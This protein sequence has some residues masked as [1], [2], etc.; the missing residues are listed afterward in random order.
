MNDDTTEKQKRVGRHPSSGRDRYATF[1]QRA[2]RVPTV[3]G[4][5]PSL[6][7]M[8]SE[9]HLAEIQNGRSTTDERTVT[10]TVE[11]RDLD[12]DERALTEFLVPAADSDAADRARLI[13]S[14]ARVQPDAK[15][16]SFGNGAATFLGR[17][18]L[19]IAAF[20]E[21]AKERRV[22]ARAARSNEQDSLFAA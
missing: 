22:R 3:S 2:A 8:G 7:P 21:S 11:T 5:P 9:A 4:R 13:E 10:V 1:T 17:Q 16:R 12:T 20:R 14:V 6:L 15:I 19:V 18:H